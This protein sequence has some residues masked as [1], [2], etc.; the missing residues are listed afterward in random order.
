M[1]IKRR[2]NTWYN[3]KNNEY[4]NFNPVTDVPKTAGGLY[5]FARFGDYHCVDRD[6]YVYSFSGLLN[7]NGPKYMQTLAKRVQRDQKTTNKQTTSQGE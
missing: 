3:D 7:G 2:G 1:A 4:I 5:I 6:D